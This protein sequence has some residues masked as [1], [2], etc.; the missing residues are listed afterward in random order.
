MS[1]LHDANSA[2]ERTERGEINEAGLVLTRFNRAGAIKRHL[3]LPRSN[4]KFK[5]Q[6][7]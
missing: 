5:I 3:P 7:E 1:A 6:P 2:M 4:S